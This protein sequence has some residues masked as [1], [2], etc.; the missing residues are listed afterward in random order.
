MQIEFFCPRWGREE[1]DF[2]HFCRMVK[3]AG[4]D[5]VEMSLPL[6]EGVASELLGVLESYSLKLIAQH[7]ETRLADYNDH[8]NEFRQRLTRLAE[9]KPLCINSQT[10]MDWFTP[11]QNIDLINIAGEIAG[12]YG[13]PVNHETHRSRFA[14]A[15]HVMP[16]YLEL[17][18]GMM[19]TLDISHWCAVAESYL[20][21]QGDS[22]E[23][24][25][26]RTAHLHCR[27]GFPEG[28]QVADPFT[29]FW[30]NALD[31]HLGWW[32]T[33]VTHAR[34]RGGKVFTITTGA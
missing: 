11:Q 25:L 21:D 10:G 17:V 33:V 30:Q 26:R 12:K 28:P 14:F 22:V 16:Q 1:Q 23:T 24:V 3:L 18:P 15:A 34:K 8:V 29:D 4:F 27:V 31:I 5:G 19:L 9:M 6:N 32:D 2:R 7:H 20:H 13:I